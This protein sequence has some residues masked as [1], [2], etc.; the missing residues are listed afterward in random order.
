MDK[1]LGFILGGSFTTGEALEKGRLQKR[2][3]AEVER[4]LKKRKKDSATV[5]SEGLS[6]KRRNSLRRKLLNGGRKRGP[7]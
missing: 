6:Q 1:C 5:G 2:K 3:K 4:S 7:N